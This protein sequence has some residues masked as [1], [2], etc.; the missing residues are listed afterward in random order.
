PPLPL[1]PAPP[2]PPPPLPPPPPTLWLSEPT[3]MPPL[4]PGV[5]VANMD[6]DDGRPTSSAAPYRASAPRRGAILSCARLAGVS[7]NAQMPALPTFCCGWGGCASAEKPSC[8]PDGSSGFPG[9][10]GPAGA[11]SLGLGAG[12]GNPGG[13]AVFPPA[14][15]IARAGTGTDG[16]R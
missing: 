6:S 9:P 16:G 2:P 10:S 15:G 3:S 5:L 4:D 1:P 14:R 8:G 11:F 7:L 12:A 13:T